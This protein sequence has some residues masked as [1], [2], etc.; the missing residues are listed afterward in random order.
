MF[1]FPNKNVNPIASKSTQQENRA[2][3][4]KVTQ[5]KVEAKG[6]RNKK[7]GK[8]VTFVASNGT[9]KIETFKNTSNTDFVKQVEI[10]KRD[11]QNNYTQHTNGCD[12]GSSTSWPTSLTSSHQTESPKFVEKRSCFKCGEFGHIIKNCTNLPKP[13]FVENAPPEKDYQRRSVSPKQDKCIVKEQEAKQ[14][15]KNIKVIEKALKPD[16]VEKEPSSSS[17]LKPVM[18]KSVNNNQSGKRQ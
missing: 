17:S 12:V 2:K 3:T 8:D 4:P 13:K 10:L 18:F 15:R 14:R 16:V 1:R 9:D 6:A 11:S 5:P 7:K